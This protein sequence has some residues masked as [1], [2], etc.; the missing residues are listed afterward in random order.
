L[1]QNLT[2][3]I[4]VH[5]YA[6]M[7]SEPAKNRPRLTALWK[8]IALRY[9]D[10]PERLF[11]ELLN[12]PHDELN[13]ERWQEMF[14]EILAI[15]RESNPNRMVIV[16]PS[17]WNDLD[18][19]DGLRLP[20][21]DHRLIATFHYY[22]PFAFT[23]QGAAWVKGSDAWKGTKWTGTPQERDELRNDFERAATWGQ[24]NRLPVYLGEFGAYREA[25]MEE[26]AAWTR[27]V[28][29]EAENWGISWSYWEFCANNFG[30]Y[31]PA[32]QAW[33]QPLLRALLDRP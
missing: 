3:V 8:Q 13:D 9:R 12:E 21:N 20:E 23:H 16:G 25:N 17:H 31:D 32:A 30:A 19:L 11:F 28:A 2:A 22:R 6:A 18:H 14:P 24:R 29:R 10:R 5:H 4:N 33:R 15:V 7:H 26:R 1:S 27:A